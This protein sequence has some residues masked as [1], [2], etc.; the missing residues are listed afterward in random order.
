MHDLHILCYFFTGLGSP[1]GVA[2]DWL[3]GNIYWTDSILNRIEVSRNDGTNRKVLLDTG[4][5]NPRAIVADPLGGYVMKYYLI[6]N[7]LH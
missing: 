7:F 5:V 2:V 6:H 4:L 1:E 3:T